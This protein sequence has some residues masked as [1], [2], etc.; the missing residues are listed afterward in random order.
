MAWSPRH[1]V[2]GS[3]AA[4]T[5]G[6]R[7]S[8]L[9]WFGALGLARKPSRLVP[10]STVTLALSAEGSSLWAS[11]IAE[12]RKVGR[13]FS[14]GEWDGQVV[15]RGERLRLHHGRRGRP[16]PIRASRQHHRRLAH[17]DT[18]RRHTRRIRATPGRH[19]PGG[20]PCSAVGLEGKSVTVASPR[21]SGEFRCATCGY[22]IIVNGAPPT[23]P[24]C[25]TTSWNPTRYRDGR[26]GDDSRHKN[27]QGRGW[28]S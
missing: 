24:M 1:R 21:V 18:V 2:G 27:P 23:C 20:R 28:R 5:D 19:G 15:R 14:L 22:G 16:G 7:R 8:R 3:G 9:D 13:C 10:F 26:S 25:R 4:R 11:V 6:L 12:R 17:P